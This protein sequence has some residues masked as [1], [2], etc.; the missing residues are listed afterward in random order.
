MAVPN[1]GQL[2]QA[3]INRLVRQLQANPAQRQEAVALLR[4]SFSRFLDSCF[5]LKKEQ[6]DGVNNKGT[7]FGSAT[8]RAIEAAI[9]SG[10]KVTL[11]RDA[12][13]RDAVKVELSCRTV[14]GKTVCTVTVTVKTFAF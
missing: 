5:T 7:L 6:R 14:Q 12:A 2:N 3:S 8:A 11:R 10:G 9:E 1:V 4:R 13:Q